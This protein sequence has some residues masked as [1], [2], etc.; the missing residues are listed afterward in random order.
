MEI[1]EYFGCGRKERLLLELGKCEWE[2]GKLLYDL[3]KSGTAE[4]FLGENPRIFMLT[5]GDRL[6]SFC[7]LARK[8]DIPDCELSPWIGFVY[9]FP[10]YRGHRFVGRL[11]AH[12]ENT[13]REEGFGR[14]FISTGH[15]GLYEKYGYAFH[16]IRKDI[17]GCDSRI[18][19]K[20][21]EE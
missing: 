6:V 5:E 7:T 21:L 2:A 3:L 20:V 8:D 1:T 16:E 14:V 9:T 11:I 13:A 12:A 4:T 18:Y 15:T 17:N 19:E 10:E